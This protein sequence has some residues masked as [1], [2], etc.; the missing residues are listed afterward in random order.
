ML[1]VNGNKFHKTKMSKYDR[2][3]HENVISRES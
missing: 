3:K 2:D 1:K